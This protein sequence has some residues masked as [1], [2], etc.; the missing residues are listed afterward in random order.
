MNITR[1]QFKEIMH[2]FDTGD[3]ESRREAVAIIFHGYSDY[4]LNLIKHK[5]MHNKYD[6]AIAEEVLQDVFLSL[7]SK[8]TK[9]SS[10]F[11]LHNW[12]KK[13]T[14]NVARDRMKKSG[15]DVLP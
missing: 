5:Y 11:A 4:L 6:E 13:Y 8:L 15:F 12:M 14:Y 7:L 9:P 10:A 2:L 3:F 1:E